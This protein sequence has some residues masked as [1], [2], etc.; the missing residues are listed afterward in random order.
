VANNLNISSVIS[1]DILKTVSSSTVIKTFGDQLKNQAKETIIS[2]ARNKVGE[3]EQ[4]IQNII[5]EEIAAGVEY[6][7]RIKQINDNK[8]QYPSEELYQKD[9]EAEKISYE[10]QKI[11]FKARIDQLKLSIKNILSDPYSKI[12]EEQKATRNRIR[13]LKKRTK[14]TEAI[15]K[16]NLSKQVALN[17][18]K[19]LAPIISLQ[20]ANQFGSVISQRKK[21]EDLVNQINEYIDT[22]V[23][24]T[25]TAAI[26]TNLRNNAVSLINNNIKKL[27]NL[28]NTLKRI[29][30][31]I[32][33][34]STI[35]SVLSAIPIPT[36]VPPGVGIPVSLI[37][38]IVK[39]IERANKLISALGAILAISTVLLTN[40]INQLNALRERLK[41]VSLKLDGKS[42]DSL[43]TLSDLFLPTGLDYPPYKGFNFKIKEEQDPRFV[44]KGNKRKYAVAINKRGIEQI[45]SEFSFTQDPNDLIEQLKLVIDQQNLQG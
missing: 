30:T 38:R 24:D 11:S 20:L 37:I 25:Q 10:S 16:I 31:T 27:E 5:Q 1:P 9:L 40:E 23:N 17:S 22:Q 13:L 18:L 32:T 15:S 41:E 35:I 26:A 34:F 43:S 33:I 45:K 42:I 29:S 8:S 19:T 21:L 4:E 3:L 36:S 12:K 28:Q 2:V 7:N 39:S 14:D 6:N 44:V